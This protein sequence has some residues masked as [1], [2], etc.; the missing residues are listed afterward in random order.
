MKR[1]RIVAFVAVLV[2]AQCFLGSRLEINGATPQLPIIFVVFWAL[3]ADPQEAFRFSWGLGLAWD[4][5]SP[6]PLGFHAL[7]FG[8]LGLTL[9]NLGRWL[10]RDSTPVRFMLCFAACCVTQTLLLL[11]FGAEGVSWALGD[12]IHFAVWPSLYTGVTGAIL[13]YVA[14]NLPFFDKIKPPPRLVAHA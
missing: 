3:W 11:A 1:I 4:L 2:A 13:C 5:V 8:I 9:A 14:A 6:G 12:W 10:N 7:V